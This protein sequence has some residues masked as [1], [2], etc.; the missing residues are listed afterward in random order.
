MKNQERTALQQRISIL[1]Q[2]LNNGYA[3]IDEKRDA[4]HDVSK[5]EDFW[6]ELLHEYEAA[7][8]ELASIGHEKGRAA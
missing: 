6:I 8:N 7:C 2:R 1:E 4:G 3:Q 5:L